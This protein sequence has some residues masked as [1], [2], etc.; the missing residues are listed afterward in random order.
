MLTVSKTNK[1]VLDK[2]DDIT[3]ASKIDEDIGLTY[4]EAVRISESMPVYA[5]L[6]YRQTLEK[7]CSKLCIKFSIPLENLNSIFDKINELKLSKYIN[8]E[9]SDKLH[10][11]RMLANKAV[12]DEKDTTEVN[13]NSAELSQYKKKINEKIKSDAIAARELF[14]NIFKAVSFDFNV[15]VKSVYKN[16]HILQDSLSD[17][18]FRGLSSRKATDKNLAGKA[19]EQLL[20]NENSKFTYIIANDLDISA[21]KFYLR[22]A[23]VFYLAAIEIDAELD[24]VPV[25]YWNDH[26]KAHELRYSRSRPEYLFNFAKVALN[27]LVED[28]FFD[29]AIFAVER[30]A[31]KGFAPAKVLFGIM[32]YEQSKYDEA[33]TYLMAAEKEGEVDALNALY[34]Y[35]SEGKACDVDADLAFKY[36]DAACK[37][38][39]VTAMFNL[40]LK[41]NSGELFGRDVERA[42]Y[43]M[44]CAIDL[45]SVRAKNSY[46]ILFS[47]KLKKGIEEFSS[48]FLQHFTNE[49]E[50]KIKKFPPVT[51]RLKIGVNEPCPCGSGKKYKKCCR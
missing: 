20:D 40:S 39:S 36:I 16:D 33:L 17:V 29:D 9:L 22:T 6:K 13:V 44:Q 10:Q 28:E 2:I 19:I 24:G 42:K 23:A 48:K 37:Q 27:E 26:N 14:L 47:D 31:K 25:S 43:W 3:L 8:K 5:L 18:I 46:D 1:L 21:I 30:A 15:N 4:A 34:L 45:G 12:H 38:G 32:L 11:L 41:Y 7:L 35:Y 50:D 51:A 49:V